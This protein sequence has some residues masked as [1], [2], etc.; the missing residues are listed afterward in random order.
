VHGLQATVFV[1]LGLYF[2]WCWSQSG[3]TLPMKTWRMRLVT[4]DGQAVSPRRA[5]ARY[6]AAWVWV[7]PP[8]LW[9][10][11]DPTLE[12]RLG[13]MVVGWAAVYGACALLHP[14]RQFWHDVVCG[15]RLVDWHRAPGHNSRP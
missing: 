8:L 3:Q 9:A 14:Q 12:R 1:V 7:L 10:W 2:V 15:T 13:W 5:L 11:A 4:R 6:L